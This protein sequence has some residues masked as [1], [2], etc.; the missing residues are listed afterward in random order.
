MANPR[1]LPGNGLVEPLAASEGAI[2]CGSR[3]GPARHPLPTGGSMPASACPQ[4]PDAA[5]A[6]TC[7]HCRG[8]C[9]GSPRGRHGRPHSDEPDSTLALDRDRAR[10]RRIGS[11]TRDHG[12]GAARPPRHRTAA[13]AWH[14]ADGHGRRCRSI[15]G[16]HASGLFAD[17]PR[18]WPS[19]PGWMRSASRSRSWQG[20]LQGM[21]QIGCLPAGTLQRPLLLGQE[22]VELVDQ[23]TSPPEG[24]PHPA[25]APHRCARRRAPGRDAPAGPARP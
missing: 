10:Q 24:T 19:L 21:G 11:S 7:R 17:R 6:P 25:A 9:P 22:P 4:Q 8:G 5:S 20:G 16:L 2:A 15:D 18:A 13:R 3:P 1:P 23:R 14:P 12:A